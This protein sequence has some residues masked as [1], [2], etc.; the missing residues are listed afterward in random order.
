ME[1]NFLSVNTLIQ[2][3]VER[4]WAYRLELV[5][6]I[7]EGDGT[8]RIVPTEHEATVETGDGQEVTARSDSP[9]TALHKAMQG[10]AAMLREAA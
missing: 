3:C 1:V 8:S 6:G 2:Q 10:M 4:R 7:L 5:Y 9:A